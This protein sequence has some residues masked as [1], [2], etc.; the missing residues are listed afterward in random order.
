[1]W[2]NQAVREC[3]GT[4]YQSWEWGELRATQGWVVWRA[5]AEDA[6]VTRAVANVL[7]R[8]VP[9]VGSNILY[10]PTGIAA[11][12]TTQEA[13]F[14]L[15]LW[16]RDFI[17]ERNA[18]FVRFDPWFAEEDGRLKSIFCDAGCRPLAD[19]W[20]LWNLPRA[21]MI[22]DTAGPEEEILRNMR[23]THREYIKRAQ[24]IGLEIEAG[25][26]LRQ[27]AEFYGLLEMSGRRQ[28]FAIRDFD[29]FLQTREKLLLNGNGLI[30]LA[31]DKGKPVAGIICARFGSTCHY[32]HGGFDWNFRHVKA[33]EIL[34]WRAIQWGK[35]LGCV[36]YNMLGSST[37]YPPVEGH[38][39]FGLYQYKKGFGA[40][41]HYTAGY[42]DLVGKPLQ[43]S[44][45]RFAERHA[46]SKLAGH[47]LHL[48]E[49]LLR[50]ATGPEVTLGGAA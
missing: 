4:L 47:L 29:H 28:G 6:G 5:V 30:L 24:R 34:H 26:D 12:D 35:A 10:A 23:A 38:R 3:D 9:L 46:Y 14:Q 2:W 43:Y 49:K 40:R 1:M 17:R 22:V 8:R 16:L 32:L 33:T 18:I 25:T 27:L 45:V 20:S 15:I 11:T 7:E 39:G 41:L 44:A 37:R 13:I 36:R 21:L 19:Q 48:R 42:L 31:R 50:P